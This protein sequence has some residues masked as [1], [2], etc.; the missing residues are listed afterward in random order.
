MGFVVPQVITESKA[1]GAQFIGNTLQF[2]DTAKHHLIRTFSGG[3]T[4]TFTW[5][6]WVKRDKF[7]GYQ[8]I[9]GHVSGGS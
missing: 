8:T 9:F 7:G 2:D 4:Q 1:S 6:G 3:N 5:S